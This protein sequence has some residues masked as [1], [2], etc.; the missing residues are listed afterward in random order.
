[1]F[2]D[3]SFHEDTGNNKLDKTRM[4]TSCQIQGTRG[5]KDHSVV[6]SLAFEIKQLKRTLI[7]TSSH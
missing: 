6:E 7:E 3:I 4:C 5:I 2:E 1:M